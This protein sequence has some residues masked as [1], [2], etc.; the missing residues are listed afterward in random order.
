MLRNKLLGDSIGMTQPMSVLTHS[1]MPTPALYLLRFALPDCS[2]NICS[3]KEFSPL[4]A[5]VVLTKFF[6][7]FP[8]GVTNSLWALTPVNESSSSLLLTPRAKNE[9]NVEMASSLE[10]RYLGL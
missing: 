10:A 8:S 2:H 6:I 4:F 7:C 1:T 5:Y 9:F 3:G